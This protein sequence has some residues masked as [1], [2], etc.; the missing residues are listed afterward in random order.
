METLTF[1]TNNGNQYIKGGLKK[2]IS[3][4]SKEFYNHIE[5]KQEA[6]YDYYKDKLDLWKKNGLLDNFNKKET[7]G[8]NLSETDIAHYLSKNQQII[9]EVTDSCNLKC[10]YCAYGELYCNYVTRNNNHLRLES[11]ISLINYMMQYWSSDLNSD[12]KIIDIGFYGGEP[13]LNIDFIK[14]VVNYT[15]KLKK[16][17]FKY[18]MTTNAILLDKYVDFLIENDFILLLSL[19]GN[20]ENNFYRFGKNKRLYNNIIE[21]INSIKNNYPVFFER[22]INFNCVLNDKNSDL[23]NLYNFFLENF[24]KV[25]NISVI[26][27]NGISKKM[28]EKFNHMYS[29]FYDSLNIYKNTNNCIFNLEEYLLED[30]QYI[31]ISK[32]LS[33]YT[34]VNI[35]SYKDMI[36][37][38]NDNRKYVPTGTCL[39][40]YRRLFLSV[41]N[42]IYPCERVG[43]NFN[44]GSIIDDIVKI[45]FKQIVTFYNNIYDKIRK[46]CY[47]CFNVLNCQ[48]CIFL[49]NF[50]NKEIKCDEK[51]SL[52][53]M[54]NIL[55]SNFTILEENN[56]LI[57]DI[58]NKIIHE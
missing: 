35:S 32:N 40:F 16:I 31:S 45:D 23:N 17:K 41:N 9:F 54:K 48:T 51:L 42:E 49:Q 58:I 2:Y 33:K 5:G 25:P 21:N 26:N 7:L 14:Q 27:N 6:N 4:I 43:Q 22:N 15:K 12:K 30:P 37:N 3:L 10:K 29:S 11:A 1:E 8:S 39:P 47:K 28:I 20:F 24:K 52:N 34:K 56:I 57:K 36:S 44:L 53:Q 55:S 38:I 13:L 50:E 19:D 18:S 46:E